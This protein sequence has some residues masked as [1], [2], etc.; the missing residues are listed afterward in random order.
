[1]DL[2]DA[3]GYTCCFPLLTT[4]GGSLIFLVLA[5]EE[6]KKKT[7]K[8]HSIC[9]PEQD[10]LAVAVVMAYAGLATEQMADALF[11]RI[12]NRINLAE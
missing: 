6:S 8:T 5:V 10:S 2:P 4:Q 7:T 1:M 12:N 9:D 3:V 11:N